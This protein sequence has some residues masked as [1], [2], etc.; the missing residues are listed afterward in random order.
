MHVLVLL[1]ELPGGDAASVDHEPVVDDL[2]NRDLLVLGGNFSTPPFPGVFAGYLLR[3]DGPG[4]ADEIVAED[5]YVTSG[6]CEAV[7]T[8]W[9]LV[10]IDSDLVP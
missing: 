6:A 8:E 1:R 4:T 7:V 2:I 5:P 3:C 9:D 10:G